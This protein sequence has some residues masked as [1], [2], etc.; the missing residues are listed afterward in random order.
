MP[1][2]PRYSSL[3]DDYVNEL[4]AAKDDVNDWWEDLVNVTLAKV[5]TRGAAAEELRHRW[6]VGPS[7]HPRFLGVVRKYYLACHNLNQEI[8]AE[9]SSDQEGVRPHIPLSD[10]SHD[11]DAET[12][13]ADAPINPAIFVGEGLFTE[14]TRDL[15]EIIGKLTY[16]PIGMDETGS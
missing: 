8:A 15:A 4:R 1:M 11:S 9:M 6:P 3:L 14:E 13:E 7:A 5:G 12:T 10:A 2:G 16:W